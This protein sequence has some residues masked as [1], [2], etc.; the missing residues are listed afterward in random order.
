MRLMSLILSSLLLTSCGDGSGG[1]ST[2]G[3]GPSGAGAGQGGSYSTFN[4]VNNNLYVMD[5]NSVVSFNITE[6]GT[7]RRAQQ[8]DLSSPN[9]ETLFNYQNTHLMVGKNTGVE[10]IAVDDNGELSFVSEYIHFNACDPVVA[11]GNRAFT[12]LRA[13]R[14]CRT[15]EAVNVQERL[16]VLDISDINQPELMVSFPMLNPKGLAVL[17]E[18]LFVCN[19]EGLQQFNI[20]DNDEGVDLITVSIGDHYSC[21]D[22]ILTADRL[23]LKHENGIIQLSWLNNKLSLLSQIEKGVLLPVAEH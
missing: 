2:G 15:N 8:Y 7:P 1:T 9:G 10:V 14:D 17:N 12:T 18:N 11:Q 6:G 4:I 22:I 23:I 13:G 19:E 20:I 5:V 16:D 21:D 3:S